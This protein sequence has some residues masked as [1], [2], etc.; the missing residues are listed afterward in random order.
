MAF[1]YA[2]V[3]DLFFA[4]RIANALTHL[5]HQGQVVDLSMDAPTALPPGTNLALVD[6]EAGEPALE[7]IRSASAAGVPVLAF[8]PHTDLA[9]REAALSAGASKVVAKSKL[10]ASFAELLAEML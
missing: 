7:T 2:V 9:L 10:T 8:G 5:G 1:V 4:D 3:N 6:L